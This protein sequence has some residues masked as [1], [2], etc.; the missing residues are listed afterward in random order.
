MPSRI[1]FI[2]QIDET[3]HKYNYLQFVKLAGQMGTNVYM[4]STVT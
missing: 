2:I 3:P 1:D 4:T